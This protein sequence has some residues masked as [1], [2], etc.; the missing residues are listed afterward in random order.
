MRKWFLKMLGSEA[1]A[2]RRIDAMTQVQPMTREK[3]L[4]GLEGGPED[5]TV[6]SMLA[7]VKG[8]RELAVRTLAS[9]GTSP[10]TAAMLRGKLAMA[11]EFEEMLTC[12]WAD[13]E[14]LRKKAEGE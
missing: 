9:A 3:I 13:L 7:I 10:E 6:K 11:S 1:D 8:L 2:R 5:P 14:R 4:S 12:C